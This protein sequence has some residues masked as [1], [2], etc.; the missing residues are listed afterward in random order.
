M[1]I[2]T[3]Y[4][5]SVSSS[6]LPPPPMPPSSTS[7]ACVSPCQESS[8]PPPPMPPSST[9]VSPIVPPKACVPPCQGSSNPDPHVAKRSQGP[10]A[11]PAVTQGLSSKHMTLTLEGFT[12][13]PVMQSSA[14]PD[15]APVSSKSQPELAPN[16]PIQQ[17]SDGQI[18][19]QPE[20]SE[21][22]MTQPAPSKSVSGPAG[23]PS[24]STP[25]AARHS[26]K[27][28]EFTV[29]PVA[30]TSGPSAT[31]SRPA[32]QSVSSAGTVKV[33][34]AGILGVAMLAGLMFL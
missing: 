20:P 24:T 25:T 10:P 12:P 18:Q 33:G 26:S 16:N 6:P 29:T 14:A 30:Y 34:G 21:P 7:R 28:G 11:S 15:G 1:D 3:H 4:W 31:I 17:I 32:V 13:P 8:L 5:T 19:Y 9:P 22:A 27:P 23:K 2:A